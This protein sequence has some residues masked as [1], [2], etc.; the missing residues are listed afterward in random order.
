[1]KKNGSQPS[2]GPLKELSVVTWRVSITKRWE[3]KSKTS[4]IFKNKFVWKQ[5]YLCCRWTTSRNERNASVYVWWRKISLAGIFFSVATPGSPLLDPPIPHLNPCSRSAE[6]SANERTCILSR[7]DRRTQPEAF[8]SQ[9][10]W[11]CCKTSILFARPVLLCKGAIVSCQCDKGVGAKCSSG[12]LRQKSQCWVSPTRA[13]LTA[14][15]ISATETS[16]T[17]SCQ[18][19]PLVLP[20]VWYLLNTLHF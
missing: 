14:K 9:P 8:R 10:G 5:Q 15:A 1:M 11:V 16:T 13:L 4:A 7:D 18:W 19:F 2:L 12:W 6:F 3:S 17:S 20:V